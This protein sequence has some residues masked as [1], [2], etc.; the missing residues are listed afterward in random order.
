ML[1]HLFLLHVKNIFTN[2]SFITVGIV[3]ERIHWKTANIP[4]LY[5]NLL[6]PF[7]YGTLNNSPDYKSRFSVLRFPPHTISS[8]QYISGNTS[9]YFDLHWDPLLWHLLNGRIEIM[10][11]VTSVF[12]R[13]NVMYFYVNWPLLANFV[14]L[15]Y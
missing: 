7:L 13:G 14:G 15:S 2:A 5:G 6:V 10:R 8:P 3:I 1:C 4:I 11:F 9:S 12:K